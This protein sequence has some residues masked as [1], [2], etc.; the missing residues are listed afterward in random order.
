MDAPF[1][2]NVP[3]PLGLRVALQLLSSPTSRDELRT[4]L[5]LCAASDLAQLDSIL[6]WFE[7]QDLITTASAD[8]KLRH[9]LTDMGR[10]RARLSTK[11]GARA[12][13]GL[14]PNQTT[15]LRILQRAK[16]THGRPVNFQAEFGRFISSETRS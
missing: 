3:L 5:D 2:V 14:D 10:T 16:L 15:V 8:P 4:V 13:S 9:H 7:Q 1:P 11:L 6:D 12:V